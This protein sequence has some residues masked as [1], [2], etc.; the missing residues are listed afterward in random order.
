MDPIYDEGPNSKIKSDVYMF[1][2]LLYVVMTGIYDRSNLPGTEKQN[3]ISLVRS[4]HDK[5]GI[6]NLIDSHIRH[7]N[8]I[9]SLGA[10][11]EIAYQCISRDVKQRPT[12][13]TIIQR[14]QDA[15]DIQ[16]Q[17]AASTSTLPMQ[18]HQNLES[19]VIPL[20][21]IHL[22]T[23]NFSEQR[24]IGGG[25]FASVYRGELSE[26]WQNRIVAIKRIKGD[27]KW[28]DQFHNELK[29]AS[30]LHH[31][32]IIGFIGYCNEAN[33][34]IIVYEY[35][36]KRSVDEQL[37]K[38]ESDKSHYLTWAQRL[39][40]CIGAARGLEYLHSGPWEDNIV[41]HRNIKSSNILVDDDNNNLVAKISS[42]GLSFLVDQ[43]QPEVYDQVESIPSHYT[44]PIYLETALVNT[45]LD[46]HSFGVVM[47]EMLSGTK[48]YKHIHSFRDYYQEGVEMLIDPVIADHINIHSFR[49]FIK[50]VHRCVS[51]TLE[52]RPSMKKIIKRLEEARDIQ[53]QEGASAITT[54]IAKHQN[55]EEF[56]IP[57]KEINFNKE[58]PVGDGGY[59]KV[60]KAQ[61]SEQ[62]QNRRSVAIKCLDP[63]GHQGKKEFDNEVKLISSFHH[64]NIIPFVGYCDDPDQMIIVSKYAINGSL[65]HHL[66]DQEKR[67]QLTWAQRLRI[68]LGA[69]K[70][71]EYLHYGLGKDRKVIHRDVKSANILLDEN[72]E[73]KICDFG[74][75]KQIP[76]NQQDSQVYTKVAGTDVYVDPLYRER[77]VLTKESDVYSFGVVLF[78]M[79]SGTLAYWRPPL[80]NLVQHQYKHEPEKLIDPVIR[81]GIDSRCLHTFIELAYKCISLNSGER[82]TMD[83]I[84]DKIDDAIDFQEHEV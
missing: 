50:V 70:G 49:A 6:D 2:V 55:L 11:K 61:L 47:L 9:R 51:L 36:I 43:N 38:P 39:E 79:L 28:H 64:P 23:E 68:C 60:Y 12:M 16:N 18:Q 83:R 30:S 71:L 3:L 45:Q 59:G 77:N 80:M 74:L 24:Y 20:E 1:G 27:Y 42:F 13:D 14:I 46:I 52:D 62:W 82:P 72:M 65:D 15:L 67:K 17:D 53:N 54:Y 69:A 29:M 37:E 66:Q 75:S 40:I 57:L 41:I 81:D 22:A 44:D 5:G 25:D 31:K 56:R 26:P 32:N 63:K 48:A 78:E 84:I 7:H 73:A 19:F 34:K 76:K 58:T 8:N 21:E 35:A 4:Y 33:E 10:V